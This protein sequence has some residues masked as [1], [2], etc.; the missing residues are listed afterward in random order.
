MGELR[1][2]VGESPISSGTQ[3]G[4]AGWDAP[5][6]ALP[7]S[8][9]RGSPRHQGHSPIRGSG[10]PHAS[11][12]PP[13]CIEGVSPM[14]MRGLPHAGYRASP[15]RVSRWV[16][17]PAPLEAMS[18]GCSPWHQA[19]L[20][21]WGSRVPRMGKPTRIDGGPGYP[22][23]GSALGAMGKPDAWLGGAPSYAWGT[24]I[25]RASHRDAPRGGSHF[26][27]SPSSMGSTGERAHSSGVSSS[28]E[29]VRPI[30]RRSRSLL[31]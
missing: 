17:L 3:G 24:P 10:L 16:P 21:P 6:R 27:A 8:G 4:V 20:V 23:G 18:R 31:I 30:P 25:P 26:P 14:R 13:P 19:G 12:P 5:W 22:E 2:Q 7:P 11:C 29:G 1:E 15:S 28:S 9:Y